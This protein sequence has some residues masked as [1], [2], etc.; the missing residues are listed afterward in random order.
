[1][2]NYNAPLNDLRFALKLAN[3]REIP[4][5]LGFEEVT[6]DLVDAIL[7]EAG[8]FASNILEPI[9]QTGD[10]LGSVLKENEVSTPTGWKDAYQKFSESGWPGLN[11]PKE[12]G[13]QG[14]PFTIA[15]AVQEIWD[16]SNMAFGLCPMLSQTA[17]EA[18]YLTGNDE[19]KDEFLPKMISG[20]WTGTMNLTEPQAGSD[21]GQIRTRA[22][23]RPD[24]S[25][26]LKGQKIYITYGDHDLTDNIIHLVLARTPNSPEGVK[27]I[28]MFI[29]P[30][31]LTDVDG[32]IQERNDIRCVSLEHKMGIHG[33]PTAVLSYG[34]KEGAKGFLVGKENHG[35]QYMFIMMNKARHAVGIESYG[36]AERSFQRAI[37][38][39]KERVQGKAIGSNDNIIS[40]IIDHPDVQRML[41]DMKSRI[42]AMRAL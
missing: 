20:E 39:A 17:A 16:A 34:D 28:S 24:G 8:K 15:C 27:G 31:Y 40:P 11:L 30:K 19:Q 42:E 3:I 6:D 5:W 33:S 2:P 12:Y 21:L 32:N 23:P 38:F 41:L 22:V 14:L 18:I 26:L 9:N 37:K 13:G 4:S 10:Q 36:V 35:L 1:M 29:V 7:E 25:F